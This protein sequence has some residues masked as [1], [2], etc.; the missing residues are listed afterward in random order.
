MNSAPMR[1]LCAVLTFFCINWCW[2]IFRAQTLDGARRIFEAMFGLPDAVGAVDG[3][4]LNGA[5]GMARIMP[6]GYVT[7]WEPVA[8][9][10][11]GAFVVWCLPN[12]RR[13]LQACR[14]GSG[15]QLPLSFGFTGM[16]GALWALFLAVLAGLSL[17]MLSR[18]AVFLYFQF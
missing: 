16:R 6:N 18:K 12:C 3:G 1:F 11:V 8:L 10:L 14:E 9:L 15:A 4:P 7:G 13:L 5:E 2:V 17:L